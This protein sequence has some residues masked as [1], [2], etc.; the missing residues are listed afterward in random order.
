[1]NKAFKYELD[2]TVEQKESISKTLGCVRKIYNLML[3]DKINHYEQFKENL[4]VNPTDYKNNPEFSYL[5][6]VDSQALCS[7]WTNLMNAFNNFFKYHDSKGVGFPKFKCKKNKQ[8]YTTYN[9]GNC[10]RINED[11]Q[12]IKI[13]K[14]G[15]VKMF[16]HRPIQGKIKHITIERTPSYRYYVSILCELTDSEALQMRLKKI[17]KVIGIDLG[18]KEFAVLSDGLRIENPRFLKT[19]EKHLKK[20]QKDLSRCKKD[21]KNSDKTRIKLAK[22]HEYIKNQRKD[23][24]HKLSRKIINENQ[25]IVFE[26][27]KVKGM[28]KNHNLSKSISDVG[29]TNFINMIKYKS[30]WAGREIIQ[31]NQWFPSSQLCSVCGHKNVEV[32]SLSVRQWTCDHCG[33][34]HDRDLNASINILKEGLKSLNIKLPYGTKVLASVNLS[35]QTDIEEEAVIEANMALA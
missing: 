30:E 5:K 29:W 4:K 18:L 1:M 22:Q 23:F 12:T 10:I 16:Y 6:E 7:S 15:W 26:D 25:V 35:D 11:D 21:S 24:H 27:L 19:S 34:E 8:S 2:L 31:V 33:S 13:P 3:N 32:K 28:L 9:L 17:N 14:I 20:L